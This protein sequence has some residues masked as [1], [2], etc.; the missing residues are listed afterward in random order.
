[1]LQ[2]PNA[3][4]SQ[5]PESS[6]TGLDVSYFWG[7]F[8]RRWLYFLL[9]FIVVLGV[10]AGIVMYLPPVFLSEGRILVE[11]QQIPVDLVRPTITAGAKERIQVLEQRV[12]TRD[13]LLGIVKKFDLYADRPEWSATDRFD[14]VRE[15]ALIKPVELDSRR[16]NDVTIAINVGFEHTRPDV[17]MRVANEL[18]TLILAEDARNRANRAAETTRFLAREVSRLETELGTVE[19]QII[20]I[21]RRPAVAATHEVADKRVLQLASMKAE[22]DIKLATFSKTHPEIIRLKR[23][24]EAFEKLIAAQ[25]MPEP[26]T[27][28]TPTP[29]PISADALDGLLGQRASLQKSLEGASQKLAAARLGES[30]ERQQFSERLEVIEQAVMPQKPIKPNRP[31]FLALVL[32]FAGMCGVGCAFA[33]EM[34]NRS[35]RSVRDLAAVIDPHLLVPIPYIKTKGEIR[36]RRLKVASS[37]LALFAVIGG[38]MFAVDTYVRPLDLLWASVVM[39]LAL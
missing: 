36:A 10:G 6:E 20:E 2:Y 8:K 32:G 3:A 14:R 12:M 15:S 23:Q 37:L 11:S 7:V 26:T 28:P 18:M 27:A 17:A 4:V 31:K 34:L 33:A 21:R 9:P 13:N 22:L 16:R 24:I 1:M 25:P 5:Y 19:A 29:A 38:G 35:I 30:L 39:R